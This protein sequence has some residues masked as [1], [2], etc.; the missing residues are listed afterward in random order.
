MRQP[1]FPHHRQ[2]GVRPPSQGR[3]RHILHLSGSRSKRNF[4]GKTRAA[5]V[6]ATARMTILLAFSL[7]STR[8][9]S[10]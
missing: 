5:L 2:A 4:R 1:R 9:A 7:G 3:I 6:R 8:A 10:G